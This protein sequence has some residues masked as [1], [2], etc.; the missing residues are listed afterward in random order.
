MF[1]HE[2]KERLLHRYCH[3]NNSKLLLL[4][5][6]ANKLRCRPHQITYMLTSGLLPEPALRLGNRRIFT[7]RDVERIRAMLKQKKG[8]ND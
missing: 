4:G 3:M 1:S 6:V 7:E 5:Q 8:E 2:K